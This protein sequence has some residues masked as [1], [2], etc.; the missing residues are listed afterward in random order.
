MKRKVRN[1][2]ALTKSY[3]PPYDIYVKERGILA[4]QQRRAYEAIGAQPDTSGRANEQA[5]AWMCQTFFDVRSLVR[6]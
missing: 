4:N 2:V 1:F 5:R 6:S 3:Q